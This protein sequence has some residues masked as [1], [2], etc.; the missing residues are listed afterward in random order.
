LSGSSAGSSFEEEPQHGKED[1]M[2]YKPLGG[3]GLVVSRA[4]LGTMVFGE[5]GRR[6]ADEET[7]L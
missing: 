7:S 6:G 5:E 1:A 4:C 3:S 2:K